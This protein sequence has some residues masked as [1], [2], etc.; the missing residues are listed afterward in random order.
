[1]TAVA[2]NNGTARRPGF[3]KGQSGNPNGREPG[4]LNKVTV[5][6]RDLAKRLFDE[7]YWQRAKERLESGKMAPPL[8]QTFLAYAF[9]Q[10]PKAKED[11]GGQSLNLYTVLLGMP[12]EFVTELGKRLVAAS[13]Q[14]IEGEVVPESEPE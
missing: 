3:Q 12:P 13:G 5:E 6:I 2:K 11:Q 8:E 4:T 9:G 10:P 1:M 7:A 14:V